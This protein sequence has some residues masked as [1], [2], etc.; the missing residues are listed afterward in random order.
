MNDSLLALLAFAPVLLLFLLMVWAR[1]SASRAMPVTWIITMLLLYFIW[2]VPLN[3]LMASSINGLFVAVQILFIV[4]GALAILFLLR[5]SGAISVINRGF[6]NISTDRRI[7]VIIIAWFFG[8]FIEGTA[9]FGTPAALVAPLL[10]SLG[11]PAL[12][13]VILALICD[14]SAVSFGAVG[15]PTIIGVAD[16]VNTSGT[17]N[18][19]ENAGMS[20]S[21]FIDNVGIFSSLIHALPAILVPL[22]AVVFMT[23]VFG[24]RKSFREGFRVA[25]YAIFAGCCFVIPYVLSAWLL[26]PEFPSLIGSLLGLLIIIPLTR[27]GFLVPKEKWDF[28]SEEKWDSSWTGNIPELEN[29]TENISLFRAWLPYILIGSLLVLAR[30]PALPFQNWFSDFSIG[31]SG[32]FGT[33]VSNSFSPLNNPGLFPFVFIA[34]LGPLFFKMNKREYSKIWSEAFKKIKAPALALF[35]AVPLV[36]IMMDSGNNGSEMLS[37]PLILA[38]YLAGIFQEAWPMFASF[39]GILGSF[40]SGSNTVSNMLFSL[41]QYS[42]AEQLEVSR[43]IMLSLQNVGG[44]I[45]NMICVH[46]IIAACAT[47]GLVGREG[48]II[49]QNMVPV[50]LYAL[51]TGIVGLVFIYLFPGLF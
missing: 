11:F 36:R 17:L 45:G 1:W 30:I 15:T 35:F 46:N 38:A 49:R 47:V 22:I 3:G 48:L 34:L 27:R 7:Q 42:I 51:L 33:K 25:P 5:E 43:T 14:S 18:S 40:I 41:F 16:S 32:L 21:Q 24:E 44:A 8:S 37:M 50:I 6:S 29:K 9:G 12:A 31:F 26:G 19:I 23:R 20:F 10:M 28:P 39:I 13:A 4:F 2:K